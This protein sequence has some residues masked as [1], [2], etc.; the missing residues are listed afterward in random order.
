VVKE[1]EIM[2]ATLPE[3]R[4]TS[5]PWW[6]VLLQGIAAVILGLLLLLEPGATI[7]SIV[8]VVGI[9]WLVSGV[10]SI[11]SIFVDSE[12]WG[13]KLLSGVVGI[14]AGLFIVQHPLWSAV[15]IPTTLVIVIAV[16]GL[17]IGCVHLFMAFKHRSWGLGILGVL[18]VVLGLVL[19]GSPMGGVLALASVYGVLAIIGGAASIYTAFRAR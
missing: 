10:M 13:W 4:S 14:L 3:A 15:L 1:H 11:V 8:H 5:V 2:E 9:Y 12:M 18:N 16:Q 19:L 17:I 6:I 7:V